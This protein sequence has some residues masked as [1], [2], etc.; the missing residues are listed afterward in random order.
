MTALTQVLDGLHGGVLYPAFALLT[1]L[2]F[3]LP[4]GVVVPGEPFFVLAGVM[5]ASGRISLLPILGVLLLS[6]VVGPYLGYRAGR[7]LDAR[8]Q[9]AAPGSALRKLVAKGERALTRHRILASTCCCWLPPLRT[10]V[11]MLIGAAR[12][13]LRSYLT[14]SAAG[15]SAWVALFTIGGYFASSF[16][17][18]A[19][20]W[21]GIVL[22]G[23]L[24]PVALVRLARRLLQRG[25][26]TAQVQQSSGE[27][28]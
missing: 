11:P 17:E 20:T 18:A 4:V 25:K 21:V 14:L 27:G 22:I 26:G 28:L 16:F 2:L 5:A 10:T 15:T 19:A 12:Q 23:V 1:V 3:L 9:R 24:V 8:L 7:G 6:A 13:P